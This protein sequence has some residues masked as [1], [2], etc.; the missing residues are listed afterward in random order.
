MKKFRPI[1]LGNCS[2][3]IIT[4]AITNRISP[5]GNRILPITKLLLLKVDIFLHSVVEHK[6]IHDV[7]SKKHFGLVLKL[8]YDKSYD[9]INWEFLEDMLHSRRFSLKY[10]NLLKSNPS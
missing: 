8:G 5:V 10:R 3:K 1:S 9:H 7:H 6:V 2:L 4:K